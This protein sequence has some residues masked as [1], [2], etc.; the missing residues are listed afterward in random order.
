[1]KALTRDTRAG[2]NTH[3]SIKKT[4]TVSWLDDLT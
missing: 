3:F 1:M 4:E 2:R